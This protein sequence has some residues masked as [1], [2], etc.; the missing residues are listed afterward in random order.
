MQI[1]QYVC[2]F[3]QIL[4]SD[5][6]KFP[7]ADSFPLCIFDIAQ[8]TLYTSCIHNFKPLDERWPYDH[9]CETNFTFDYH[10]TILQITYHE[11]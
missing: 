10:I 4:F 1:C 2:M 11:S 5:N 7:L 9:E 3:N 8:Y 6:I